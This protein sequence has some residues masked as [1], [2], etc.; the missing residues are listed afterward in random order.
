M[1]VRIFTFTI[2]NFLSIFLDFHIKNTLI[3]QC[4]FYIHDMSML[5]IFVDIFSFFFPADLTLEHFVG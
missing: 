4:F 5:V 1:S 2:F 3:L